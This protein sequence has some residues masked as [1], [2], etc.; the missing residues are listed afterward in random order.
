MELFPAANEDQWSLIKSVI[1]ECDYYLLILA[2]RYGSLSADGTSYTEME[3]RHALSTGKPIIA[4]LHRDPL[5]IQK[6][7]TE[8]TADGQ[9]KLEAFRGLVSK[10]MCKFWSTPAELGSVVSRSVIN[11]Q[12]KHPA[13]GW[14]RGDVTT[15][16]EA[17]MQIVRLNKQLDDLR[18]QLD[19]ARTQAP[20]GTEKLSQGEDQMG[21][22]FSFKSIKDAQTYNW[23]GWT[24]N[25]TW[26]EV[27]YQLSPLMMHEASDGKLKTAL[28]DLLTTRAKKFAE[29]EASTKGHRI[30]RYEFEDSDF[31]TVKVQLRALGLITQ[32]IKGRSVKDTT[33]YWTLTPYGDEMMNRLRAIRSD[34]VAP[35]ISDDQDDDEE[36]DDTE[37]TDHEEA[38]TDDDIGV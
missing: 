12:R 3:Y 7:F 21:F 1:D 29:S 34:F 9:Q 16:K 24:I 28:N 37:S 15:D 32:S 22:K 36:I 26:N 8:L 18:R 23:D 2:G 19:Q 11:L 17:S 5:A 38:T 27:F 4:F 30:T 6:K 35:E 20:P 25:I 31:Q 10:K 33:A 13:V 14:I